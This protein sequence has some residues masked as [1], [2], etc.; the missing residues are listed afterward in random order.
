MEIDADLGEAGVFSRD[1]AGRG[2]LNHL[3]IGFAF[4][5]PEG[6]IFPA[7]SAIS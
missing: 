3:L 4:A 7:V 2:K 5:S 1:A 6:S